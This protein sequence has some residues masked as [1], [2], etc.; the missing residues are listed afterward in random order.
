MAKCPATPGGV[1]ADFHSEGEPKMNKGAVAA[2]I[3][4][5]VVGGAIG[6]FYVNFLPNGVADMLPSR[7]AQQGP[8]GGAVP[9]SAGGPRPGGGGFGGGGGG[10]GGGGGGFGGGGF[11]TPSPTRD[12]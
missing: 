6:F 1:G 9:P 10:F 4:S 8:G 12:L 5:L 3:I 2:S 7:A 11:G